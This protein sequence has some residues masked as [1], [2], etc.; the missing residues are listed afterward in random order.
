MGETQDEIGL[1]VSVGGVD[2]ETESQPIVDAF[3]SK[4]YHP[5][6]FWVISVAEGFAI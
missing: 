1:V 2:G 3:K 6:Y 4:L 5:F